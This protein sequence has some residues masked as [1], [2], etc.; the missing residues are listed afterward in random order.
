MH[1]FIDNKLVFSNEKRYRVGRHVLFWICYWIYY[2]ML[3]AAQ[4]FGGPEIMYFNNLPYTLTESILTMIP[5]MLLAYPMLYFILPKFFLKKKYLAGF[6]LLAVVW[7]CIACLNLFMMLRVNQPVIQFLMPERFERITQRPENTTFYMGILAVMKGG[8]LGLTTATGVKLMKYFYLK[9]H[10]NML[11]QKENAQSQLQLLTAQVHPH[12]LFNTLNNIF[13]QTQTESPKGSKMIMG[14]SDMLR[15]ILYEGQKPLVPLQQELQ[16]IT[17]YINLEKIRYGNKLDVHMSF[18]Q[19]TDGV[20]IAPLLLLPFVENCFKHGAS[21]VLENP[22]IN[23]AVELEDTTLVM[24][25]M[26]GKAP[27]GKESRKPGIGIANVQQRLHLLYKDR[28]ELQVTEDEEVFVVNLQVTL[29]RL[30]KDGQ[31]TLTSPVLSE[32]GYA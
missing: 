22:W 24:K 3:H 13:S 18:P 15:Y 32:I 30:E 28:H 29:T 26:N 8:L 20:Y 11:L 27:A 23:L 25:L 19:K 9:E 10:H 17:E 1:S 12:F 7:F 21:H 6:V 5:H 16:M 14:L 2:G 4:S 31:V